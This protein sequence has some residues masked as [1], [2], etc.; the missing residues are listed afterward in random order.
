MVQRTDPQAKRAKLE[1]WLRNKLPSA[2]NITVSPLVKA[3][4]G[5]GSEIHFFDASW[6]EGGKENRERLVIRE[7]PM[8]FRVFPEYDLA[9]EYKTMKSLQDSEVPVPKMYWLETDGS[10][11]GAPFY[12]MGKVDG[13]VL[14]PQQFGDEPSGPLYEASPEGR[15]GMCCQALEVMAKINTVD[16]ANLGLSYV[17]AP[18]SG[19]DALDEQMSFYHRMAEWAEVEPRSLLDDAF[20]WFDKNR[21]EP[22]HVSLCWG[23]ARLGNLIYRDGDIV[24]VL[25][26]DMTHI[27]IAETDLAWFLALGWLTNESG[28]RGARW[29]GLPGRE[30]TIQV[31]EN[32]LGRKLENLFYH[33]AFAFLRL[34]IIFWRVVKS[35][36][37]IPPEYIPDNPPLSKLANMLGLG[38]RI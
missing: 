26:W 28:L 14:D 7:E 11:L 13:E 21:F 2:E 35:M 4:G 6:Q 38:D 15:R 3:A 25:D 5:Y 18:K 31:Y 17:G 20:N 24:A 22:E 37:G 8:V 34:G 33:E 32:A 1:A 36:P 19:T 16:C 9:R 12:V 10:V 27:G 29:E 30:E 23:D